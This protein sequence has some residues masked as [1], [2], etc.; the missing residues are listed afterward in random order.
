MRDWWLALARR[1]GE[2][3]GRTV[4]G[5]SW[6]GGQPSPPSSQSIVPTA[7]FDLKRDRFKTTGQKG[8]TVLHMSEV[9]ELWEGLRGA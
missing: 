2:G 9:R 1:A 8:D 6:P 5:G 7:P 4:A 3:G